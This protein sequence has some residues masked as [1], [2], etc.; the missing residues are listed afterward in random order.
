MAVWTWVPLCCHPVNP[1][2]S[3]V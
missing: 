3:L 1:F 2:D